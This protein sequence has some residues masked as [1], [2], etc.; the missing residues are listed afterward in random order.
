MPGLSAVAQNDTLE[1]RHRPFQ[2]TFMFPPFSSNGADNVNIINDVSLNLFVGVSGGVEIFEAG[3]FI[4]VDRFYVKGIQLAGFG[5]TVGGTMDGLQWAGFYNV[6][7]T[8]ANGLQA[9]GFTNVVGSGM[10][11]IQAAGFA[12]VAGAFM[13]GI[14]GAGFINISGGAMKGIQAAGFM[15]IAEASD[16]GI[17]AAGFGNI[18]GEGTTGFQ[19]AGFLNVAERVKGLQAAG[20]LNVAGHVKGVQ[21]S[22]FINVCDSIDGV[23]IGVISVVKKNGYRKLALSVSEVQYANLSFRLGVRQFYNIFSFGKPFGP[24]GRW[25]YGWGAGTEVDLTGKSMLN[26]EGIIHHEFWIPNPEN[27]YFFYSDRTNLYNSARFLFGWETD[28]RISL[29]LG[30]TFNVAVAHTR[31]DLSPRAWHEIAPYAIFNRTAD[32]YRE[33]NVQMWFGL[34][35]EIRF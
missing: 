31:A 11:G 5:N 13:N 2:F 20:F 23:P 35:G 19:G 25:M 8:R 24:G 34:M 26:I 21:L 16:K 15:N 27:R 17:Q 18:S 10:N 6:V 12:N 28:N 30:P 7:G 9:A 4:N 33:T 1:Y 22:G 14:Q 3:S 32:N 29:H